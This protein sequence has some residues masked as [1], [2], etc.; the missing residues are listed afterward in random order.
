MPYVGYTGVADLA[1]TTDGFALGIG[2][3]ND[4]AETSFGENVGDGGVVDLY[5]NGAPNLKSYIL[6]ES[7]GYVFQEDSFKIVLESS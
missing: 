5:H 2:A 7:S 3:C 4:P 1:N 6:M